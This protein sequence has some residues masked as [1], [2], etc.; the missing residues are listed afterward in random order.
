MV[1]PEHL[2]DVVALIRDVVPVAVERD[3]CALL[4]PAHV[5]VVGHHKL[6]QPELK[7]RLPV[8]LEAAQ[9]HVGRIEQVARV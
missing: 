7:Q 4:E 1:R 6:H 5:I 9:L 2:A 3:N 8:A